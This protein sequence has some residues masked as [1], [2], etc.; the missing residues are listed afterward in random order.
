M[1]FRSLL[2]IVNRPSLLLDNL[3]AFSSLYL[4]SFDLSWEFLSWRSAFLRYS[5]VYHIFHIAS[6]ENFH[7]LW[8][9]LSIR[10]SFYKSL[11]ILIS[12]IINLSFLLVSGQIPSCDITAPGKLVVQN[13]GL[14]FQNCFLLNLSL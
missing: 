14:I 13:R 7:Q 9:Q 12:G 6:L 8:N 1:I 2:Y 4:Q 3:E 11:L 10:R 5:S